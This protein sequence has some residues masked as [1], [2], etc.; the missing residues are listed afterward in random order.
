MKPFP[1]L[2]LDLF[3]FEIVRLSDFEPAFV[4]T[5]TPDWLLY[6]AAAE[7]GLTGVITH[8][9]SQLNQENEVRALDLTG[10]AVVTY[11]K[12]VADELTKWGLLMAYAPRI[13]STLDRGERGALILPTPGPIN[14]SQPRS[15]LQQIRKRERVSAQELRDR[16][17]KVMRNELSRRN[18]KN[19]WP[20]DI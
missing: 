5:A 19:L 8:D 3:G 10:G 6:L 14:V 12:G 15:L 9:Q 7:R 2:P 17:D 13:T 1:G 4:N 11:R 16:A 20:R 18:M